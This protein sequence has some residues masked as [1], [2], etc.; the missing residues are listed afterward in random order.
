MTG[1]PVVCIGPGAFQP[2]QL[3]EYMGSEA[4]HHLDDPKVANRFLNQYLVNDEL[5]GRASLLTRESAI[6]MFGLDGIMAQ[7]HDFLGTAA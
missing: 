1:T 5:A 6:G 3:L 2:P 7:W 4:G